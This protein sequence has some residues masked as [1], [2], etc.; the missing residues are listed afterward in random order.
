MF[1]TLLQSVG[2]TPIPPQQIYQEIWVVDKRKKGEPRKNRRAVT[3]IKKQVLET[4]S[5]VEA[6]QKTQ[7]Q[8]QTLEKQKEALQLAE[9]QIEVTLNLLTVQLKKL[10]FE[11]AVQAYQA[12]QRFE[13][14]VRQ[15]YQKAVRLYEEEL[16]RKEQEE[17]EDL[18]LL[19]N[20]L[21]AEE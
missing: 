8:S 1:L 19:L 6:V 21:M 4:V 2:I 5:A 12:K 3:K 20:Y 10:E 9:Q 18:E 17:R 15:E 13:E 7:Q 16:R 14:Y 11:Q